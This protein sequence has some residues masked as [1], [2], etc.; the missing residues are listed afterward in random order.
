MMDTKKQSI[1]N[2]KKLGYPVYMDSQYCIDYL[3]KNGDCGK[4]EYNF[5]CD[6]VLLDILRTNVNIFKEMLIEKEEI[7]EAIDLN[8][9][10]VHRNIFNSCKDC[11]NE[12]KCYII[13][14]KKYKINE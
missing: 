1:E 12:D 6:E 3:N 11:K 13:A 10:K 2:V 14:L 9:C 8:D 5:S 7:P 4:C